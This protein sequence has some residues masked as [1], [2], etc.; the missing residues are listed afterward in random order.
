L[1]GLSSLNKELDWLC[2]F[3]PQYITWERKKGNYTIRVELDKSNLPH[4][5]W[6]AN[7]ISQD[8]LK[9]RKIKGSIDAVTHNED[10]QELDDFFTL[11]QIKG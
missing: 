9:K 5:E 2:V 4:T 7:A 11:Q 8:G 3:T 1:N 6:V 10:N